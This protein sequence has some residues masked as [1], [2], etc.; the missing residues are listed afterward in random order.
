MKRPRYPFVPAGRVAA[1]VFFCGGLTTGAT[2]GFLG[3][4]GLAV[5]ASSVGWGVLAG[6]VGFLV[7]AS[8]GPARPPSISQAAAADGVVAGIL[9]GLI[10]SLLSVAASSGLGGSTLHGPGTQT[11]IL[12]LAAGLVGGATAGAALGLTVLVAGGRDRLARVP[13]S[14]RKAR[15]RASRRAG[16]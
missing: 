8:Q 15:K 13:V 9:I 16:R 7:F 3:S 12:I 2:T 5:G 1:V 11:F 6:L 14:S 10:G 4:S